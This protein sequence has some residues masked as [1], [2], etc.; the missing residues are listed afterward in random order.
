VP[1]DD[2]ARALI[3]AMTAGVPPIE[4]LD[5]VTA[6]RTTAERRLRAQVESAHV[7]SVDDI[8]M[9]GD[10]GP[11]RARIYRPGP[12]PCLP[13]IVFFHGGGW[14]ICDLDSHDPLCRRMANA[15]GAVVVSVDYRL[16]PEHRFPAAADDALAALRWVARNGEVLGIDA[17]FLAAAGDSAGGNLAAS[18]CVR[19]RD[20][21]WPAIAAQLLVYPV[22]DHAFDTDSYRENATGY[23]VTRRAME[24]FWAHY[25]GPEGDGRSPVASPL[26]AGSL[27]G[28]P[29]AVIVTAGYDPLRDE[30]LAYAHRLARAGVDVELQHHAGMYHGFFGAVAQLPA[31]ARANSLA[32]AALQRLLQRGRTRAPHRI[33][34]ATV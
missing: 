27:A 11:L 30:G 20:E 24:W 34:E 10:T 32:F 15:T 19:A 5:P 25:L 18:A 14:V 12:D 23:N 4:S 3:D 22:L 6:R 2:D 31:A 13:G 33:E 1:L 26:R 28:L 16:A 29:P 17:R 9:D 8:V 7:R 21:G